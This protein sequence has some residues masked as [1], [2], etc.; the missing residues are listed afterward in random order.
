M[1]SCLKIF[2]PLLAF[3]KDCIFLLN[4]IVFKVI[5]SGEKLYCCFIDYEKA[6]DRIDRPLL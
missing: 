3:R 2:E 6:F 4:V 5:H 1:I